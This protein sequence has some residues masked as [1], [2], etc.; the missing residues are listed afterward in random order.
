MAKT[1]SQFEC[2]QCGYS[3][4]KWLGSCPSCQS[5]NTFEEVVIQKETT[6][7]HKAK[8][9]AVSTLEKPLKI[10][11]I[12][13]DEAERVHTFI[14]ELDRVLGGG[15]MPG[16]FVLLG[17]DP[18]IGKSTLTLQ[19]A[20]RAPKLKILYCSGE[21]SAAQIGQRAQRLGV[22]SEN[23][24]IYSE[25]DL[26]L[27]IE[28]ATHMKPDV[29][30]IDS[31]QTV[32]R[33]ELTSMPGSVAQLRECSALLMRLSKQQKITTLAVGH[34][35]KDGE[36]AGPRVLE[37]MV[38]TVLMFEG[39]KNYAYRLLRSQKNRFGSTNEIGVFEMTET[40]L[41]DVLNPSQLFLPEYQREISGS[42]I[43]CSMEGSRPLLLEV[44][45]LVT[46]SSFGTPQRMASG[47]DQKRLALLIAVLEKRAGYFFGN[48]DVFLN[49]A[50]GIKIQETSSDLGIICALA[51][52][53]TD[54]VIQTKTAILGEV[55][56]GAEVRAIRSIDQR[57]QE[58]KKM[59]FEYVVIPKANAFKQ[60]IG[61]KL[62]E[63]ETVRDALDA[64]L[65]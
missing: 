58:A 55:G 40:G 38:D 52:G 18:G 64:V 34:M 44:Q 24:H 14:P 23:L 7:I 33:T 42:A 1:R 30:I 59:G 12:S 45:A 21:E 62:I 51:S 35:T 54:R 26:A 27:I 36:L 6:T 20:G 61:V 3:A 56:L 10:S 46:E 17:G 50:G 22:S 4:S 63:V 25:T 8:L 32:F 48:K 9:Q 49:I 65:Y 31:I 28:Q 16:S 60:K 5:W 39:E 41:K 43:V 37:H 15:F 47:F 57:V 2:T 13:F 29:L 11:E 53:L 19:I